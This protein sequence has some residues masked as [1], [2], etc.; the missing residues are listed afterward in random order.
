MTQ[1]ATHQD[2][3]H[4]DPHADIT[5]HWD[6]WMQVRISNGTSV[7]WSAW[8]DRFDIRE[9]DLRRDD[10][11]S[12]FPHHPDDP[13]VHFIPVTHANL[14][15]ACTTW[16]QGGYVSAGRRD[17]T[18]FPWQGSTYGWIVGVLDVRYRGGDTIDAAPRGTDAWQPIIDITADGYAPDLVSST[19]LRERVDGWILAFLEHYGVDTNSEDLDD[20]VLR[21]TRH[22]LPTSSNAMSPAPAW[23]TWLEKKVTGLWQSGEWQQHHNA[24]T[25][26]RSPYE[27]PWYEARTAPDGTRWNFLW[28]GSPFAYAYSPDR[29]T[30]PYDCLLTHRPARGCGPRNAHLAR[31]RLTRLAD[32]WM[33]GP[34]LSPQARTAWSAEVYAKTGLRNPT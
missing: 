25:A 4:V 26:W 8:P 10:L 13:S 15:D 22:H 28:T 9:P 1:P 12:L 34:A 6:G 14:I 23:S 24:G 29:P 31:E 17:Y 33:S 7:P 16:M 20:A 32:D 21:W 11:K 18:R 3:V 30:S 19:W 2:L 5:F 27:R